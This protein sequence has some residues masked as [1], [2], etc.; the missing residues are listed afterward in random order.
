MDKRDALTD[1]LNKMLEK[2]RLY[3]KAVQTFQQE[4]KR[5]QIL[6]ESM[7]PQPQPASV[8][9]SVP[10]SPPGAAPPLPPL[11]PVTEV[12]ESAPVAGAELVAVPDL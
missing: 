2:Q 12:A 7:Q 9:E 1:K 8:P 3:F 11:P 5:N 10:P 6:R 4:C